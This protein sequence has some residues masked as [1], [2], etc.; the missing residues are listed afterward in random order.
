MA[1]SPHKNDIKEIL[2]K[3]VPNKCF[4][5]SGDTDQNLLETENDIDEEEF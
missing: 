4:K 2:Y 3:N 5:L 1:L